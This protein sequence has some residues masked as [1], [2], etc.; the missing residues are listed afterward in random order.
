[1]SIWRISRRSGGFGGPVRAGPS[2]PRNSRNREE[3]CMKAA[4]TEASAS[5]SEPRKRCHRHVSDHTRTMETRMRS[6][7][8]AL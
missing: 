2:H 7:S 5:A 6:R 4:G 1:M 3:I 8:R